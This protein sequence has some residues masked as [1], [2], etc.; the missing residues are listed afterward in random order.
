MKRQVLAWLFFIW[1]LKV[2]SYSACEATL[3]PKAGDKSSAKPGKQLN[4]LYETPVEQNREGDRRLYEADHAAHPLRIYQKGGKAINSGGANNLKRPH[5]KR[6]RASSIVIRP[7]SGI[8]VLLGQ[9]VLGLLLLV[10]YF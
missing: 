4:Y 6:N 1:S 2:L 9:V 10:L 8:L 7:S 5:T 3:T